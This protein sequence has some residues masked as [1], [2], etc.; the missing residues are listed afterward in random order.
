M[1]T[2]Y[3]PMSFSEGALSLDDMQQM[4]DNVQYVFENTPRMRYNYSGAAK[5]GQL[6][7]LAGTLMF[8]A[9]KN[10]TQYQ[11]A[12]F[13]NFFSAGCKP[14]IT[15][16]LAVPAAYNHSIRNLSGVALPDHRGFRAYVWNGGYDTKNRRLSKASRVLYIAVGY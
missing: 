12:Y 14:I 7:I 4:A 11:N 1:A 13:G 15:T 5:N 16:S 10:T 8:P 2:P 9:T 6:R 3:K